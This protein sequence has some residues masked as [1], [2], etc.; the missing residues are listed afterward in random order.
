MNDRLPKRE[1]GFSLLE[2]IIAMALGMI[3]LGAAVQIYIQGVSATWTV[4]QRAELQQDFRAASNMLTKDL[5]LAGAGLGNGVAVPLPSG[6]TPRYGC[7]QVNCYLN[8]VA[9]TYPLQGTT[10]YLYGLLPGYNKGPTLNTTQGPTDVVTVIYTDTSFYLNCYTPK[11]T[12]R[13]V[14]TFYQPNAPSTW[15]TE[16][17]L[18]GVDAPTAPQAI[19]DTVVGLTTGDL[20]LMTLG[21]TTVVG[22]VTGPVTTGTDVNG[23]TTY[24]V[25]FANSD[26]LKM[27]QTAVGFGLNTAAV[28]AAGSSSS[29][30]CG[31][32]GPC[33]V[34]VITYYIDNTSVLPRLMRQISGHTPMPVA[35]NVVY[36]KFTYD[37]FNDSTATAAISCVNPGQTGDTC[38][39]GTT[40]GLLPNQITKINVQN[41]AMDGTQVGSQFG[42]GKGYQSLDLQTSVSARDLTYTNQYPN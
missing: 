4:T 7:D 28:N 36:M 3:V 24:I 6:V 38:V 27:N 22:E 14:V 16:G 25:P 29:A 13:G 33:R 12:A 30:P 17:C 10:P 42:L 37:L 32:S 9:G 26:A 21:G 23:K 2:M 15:A 1:T 11:A 35:E 40:T 39:S 34:L 41:M 8:G 5:S 31:G 18:P 20:V 19:N